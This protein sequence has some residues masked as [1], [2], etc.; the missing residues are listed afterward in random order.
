MHA[1]W[2]ALQPMHFDVSIIF[3]TST[4]RPGGG[5]SV[6]VAE[7]RMT[8][9]GLNVAISCPPYATGPELGSMLTRNALNSGVSMLASPT[10]GV[11]ELVPA[12]FLASPVKPQCNGTPTTCTT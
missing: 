5:V 8:S 12:P 4:S 1:D 10:K 3:A 6:T 11:S 9:N 2:Q 7:R